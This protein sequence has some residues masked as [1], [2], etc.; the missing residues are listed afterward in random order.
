M[1]KTTITAVL[2]GAFIALAAAP[3]VD[4]Q[5][6]IKSHLKLPS[7]SLINTVNADNTQDNTQPAAAVD[8]APTPA[9]ASSTETLT[10]V[11]TVL[12][13]DPTPAPATPDPTPAPADPTPAPAPTPVFTPAPAVIPTPAPVAKTPTQAPTKS[14]TKTKTPAVSSTTVSTTTAT[15]SA[16]FFGTLGGTEVTANIYNTSSR[17]PADMTRILLEAALL[18]G[19]AGLVLAQER[20]LRT[21]LSRVWG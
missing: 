12:T 14:T 3:A 16:P 18:L 17:L 8:A 6:K 20:G 15:S 13:P 9:P 1:K 7:F 19:A 2:F 21:T 10:P 4:V 11:P 5:A